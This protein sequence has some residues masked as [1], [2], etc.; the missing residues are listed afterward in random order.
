[1]GLYLH[2]FFLVM[3]PLLLIPF[4]G[5]WLVIYIIYAATLGAFAQELIRKS[6]K[7]FKK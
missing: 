4:G 2:R 3:F 1:M 6:I 5:L 7:R